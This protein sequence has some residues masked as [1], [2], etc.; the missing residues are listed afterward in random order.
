MRKMAV[1]PTATFV[2]TSVS[3]MPT[4]NESSLDVET[5]RSNT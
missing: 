3:F 1:K 2:A 5:A 4:E